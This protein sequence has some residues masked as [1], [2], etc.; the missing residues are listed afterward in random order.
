MDTPVST[1]ALR[2][3]REKWVVGLLPCCGGCI[4]G[5]DCTEGNPRRVHRSAVGG[6][7]SEESGGYKVR[8]VRD[9]RK[10]QNFR[11]DQDTF[12]HWSHSWMGDA[13]LTSLL[14]S[15]GRVFGLKR[16]QPIS[17][18]VHTSQHDVAIR[19]NI[20]YPPALLN[21]TLLATHVSRIPNMEIIRYISGNPNT[22]MRNRTCLFSQL[23]VFSCTDRPQGRGALWSENTC[24]GSCEI[25]GCA[26]ASLPHIRDLARF[27]SE[28][29]DNNF[30]PRL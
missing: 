18:Q 26:A 16:D 20:S 28:T 6:L 24:I 4:L 7:H 11:Y 2:R 29:V 21:Q 3:E 25:I 13:L 5:G 19:T 27:H 22:S 10:A 8:A 15:S 12:H 9:T 1:P 30:P 17:S 14:P 23:M